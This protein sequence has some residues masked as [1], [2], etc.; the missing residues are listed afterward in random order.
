MGSRY[1]G[2]DSRFSTIF[3]TIVSRGSNSHWLLPQE[4]FRVLANEFM[5]DK[6]EI[7][8]SERGSMVPHV[9]LDPAFHALKLGSRP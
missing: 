6:L 3:G 4:L 2:G 8:S 9:A 5:E 1:L 7:R